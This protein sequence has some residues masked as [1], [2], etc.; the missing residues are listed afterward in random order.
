MTKCWVE[1][2]WIQKLFFCKAWV[3]QVQ[4]ARRKQLPY[5][6][7]TEA[8]KHNLIPDDFSKT[9]ESFVYASEADL[10]NQ[11]L[12]GL[13]AKKWKELNPEMKGN[14]RDND[15]L[16]QLIVLANLESYNAQLIKQ[17]LTPPQRILILNKMAIEQL[18][19]LIK[20]DIRLIK[21]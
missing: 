14:I 1:S 13:T 16:E 19:I 4:Q 18:H 9:K 8:V 21:S 11:A 17:N 10:L 12:F 6:I 2:T 3:Q 20:S 15:S 5:K 7:H